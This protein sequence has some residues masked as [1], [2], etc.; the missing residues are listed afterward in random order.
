[1]SD[2][3]IYSGLTQLGVKTDLPTHPDEAVLERVSNPQAGTQ[4]CV[5][6]VAHRNSPR[7]AQ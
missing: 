3:T 1:M 5:R 2:Q 7:C 6:F 4:Y